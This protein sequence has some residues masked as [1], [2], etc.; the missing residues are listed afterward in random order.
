[1]HGKEKSRQ[2]ELAARVGNLPDV[3]LLEARLAERTA[4]VE[5]MHALLATAD[6]EMMRA[7]DAAAYRQHMQEKTAGELAAA[8]ALLSERTRVAA[9][10]TAQR[11]A[12]RSALDTAKGEGSKARREAEAMSTL[13]TRDREC[14]QSLL[15]Y[16]RF[17]VSDNED[18]ARTRL[19]NQY[20]DEVLPRMARDMA[21]HGGAS[22]VACG[23]TPRGLRVA[24]QTS[25]TNQLE[26]AEADVFTA[27]SFLESLS[28]GQQVSAFR[29]YTAGMS[30]NPSEHPWVGALFR[31]VPPPRVISGKLFR[32]VW[33]VLLQRG[34]PAAARGVKEY[35]TEVVCE[36]YVEGVGYVVPAVVSVRL[37]KVVDV[38][39]AVDVEALMSVVVAPARPHTAA[40]RVPPPPPPPTHHQE[41]TTTSVPRHRSAVEKAKMYQTS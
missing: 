38:A 29:A 20:F 39:F 3:A 13:A 23:T 21:L 2:V 9:E 37:G 25:Q 10:A 18:N 14:I 5:A 34:G 31:R 33:P 8:R 1:M 30:T 4:E 19:E 28:R 17:M 6:G 32:V 40:A 22:S 12:E 26:I 15:K 41:A 27:R 11:D 35:T 16:G 36:I 24:E 7:Q